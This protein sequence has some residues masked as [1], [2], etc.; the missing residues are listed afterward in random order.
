MQRGARRASR[1]SPRFALPSFSTEEEDD[2]EG[3]KDDNDNDD[4]DEVDFPNQSNVQR[5][6]QIVQGG[7]QPPA[8]NSCSELESDQSA[9]ERKKWLL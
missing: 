8:A 9:K 6:R 1:S 4:D 3:D 2:N 5:R 7:K